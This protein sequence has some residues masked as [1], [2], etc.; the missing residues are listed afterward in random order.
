MLTYRIYCHDYGL[1]LTQSVRSHHNAIKWSDGNGDHS[2]R[3]C[4]R[5]HHS[6]I[7]CQTIEE[8]FISTIINPEVAQIAETVVEQIAESEVELIQ[9]EETSTSIAIG[10]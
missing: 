9:D 8:H 2:I 3:S 1:N 6:C 4:P 10:P 5:R 7:G